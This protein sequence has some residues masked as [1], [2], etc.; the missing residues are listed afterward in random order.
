MWS[1]TTKSVKG[2]IYEIEIYTQ[3]ES[4]I[5]K[6]SVETIFE[7]LKSEGAKKNQNMNKKITFKVVQIK[8]LAMHIIDQKLRFYIFMVGNYGRKLNMIF[9]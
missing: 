2:S 7:N 4:W 5:Y 9:T 3:S 6:L 8:F 1:W